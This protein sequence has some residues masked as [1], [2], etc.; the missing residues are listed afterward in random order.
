MASLTV[1]NHL[2]N[3]A[4]HNED[5][6][7]H[8]YEACPASKFRSRIPAA[9]VAW[10]ECACAVIYQELRRLHQTHCQFSFS[11][12]KFVIL[13]WNEYENR[14][15]RQLRHMVSGKISE[16]QK[17]SPGWNLSQVCL[18]YGENAMSDEMVRRWCTNVHDDDRS[19]RPSLVTA[20]LLDQVNEFKFICW[21]QFT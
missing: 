8:S 4:I 14:K 12:Y 16:C 17:Y 5:L 11:V 13:S 19:G 2:N 1:Y 3:C 15:T 6:Q 9:Q 21:D 18:V 20:G 7:P 10:A